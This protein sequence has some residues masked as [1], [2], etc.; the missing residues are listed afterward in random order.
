M[1]RVFVVGKTAHLSEESDSAFRKSH[2]LRSQDMELIATY[3]SRDALK[4]KQYER[5]LKQ[6]NIE[7]VIDELP[8]EQR[9]RLPNIFHEYPP[10]RIAEIKQKISKALTGR[11][12]SPETR[13]KMAEAKRNKPSNN[14]GRKRSIIANINQSIGMKGKR[15]VA[16]YI[17]Y[18][19]PYSGK[20]VRLPEGVNPPPGFYKGLTQEQREMRREVT[21]RMW[22]KRKR[23]LPSEV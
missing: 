14:K 6:Y 15:C 16:N 7:N 19:E 13:A 22:R 1:I 21:N 4:S 2:Q 8:Q 11:K 9:R 20:Q 10:E 12:L 3:S 18:S 17:T 5:A 23:K